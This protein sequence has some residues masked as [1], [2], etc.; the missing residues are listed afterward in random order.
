M[1]G[2]RE[3]GGKRGGEG[4]NRTEESGVKRVQGGGGVKGKG[5]KR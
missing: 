4:N 2:E 5:W 3:L 1:E